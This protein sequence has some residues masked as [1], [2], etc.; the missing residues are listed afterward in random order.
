M[1][2]RNRSLDKR[3]MELASSLL[4]AVQPAYEHLIAESFPKLPYWFTVFRKH[5][6]FNELP[7]N[8]NIP[9]RYVALERFMRSRIRLLQEA[10]Q[11]LKP[12]SGFLFQELLR[13]FSN[14]SFQ[15]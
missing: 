6:F 15:I 9:L 14:R 5:P 3:E 10:H 13:L 8:I 2:T 1:K 12:F 4:C 11:R 7:R